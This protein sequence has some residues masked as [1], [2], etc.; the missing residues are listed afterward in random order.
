MWDYI[1]PNNDFVGI[2][3][4]V[5]VDGNQGKEF[6]R[7]LYKQYGVIANHSSIP[8][9]YQGRVRMEGNATLVIEKITPKDNTEFRCEIFGALSKRSTIQLIVAGLYSTYTS[10]NTFIMVIQGYDFIASFLMF[11]ARM[12]LKLKNHSKFLF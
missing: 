11:F 7:M 4:S 5:L 10:Q 12:K 8:A 1:D 3:F 2:I 9:L 6:K